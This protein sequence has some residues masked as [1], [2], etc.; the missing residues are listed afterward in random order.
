[1]SIEE[2]FDSP[3]TDNL[4]WLDDPYNDDVVT[5]KPL[6][7][8]PSCGAESNTIEEHDRLFTSLRRG[9]KHTKN[10]INC[11]TRYKNKTPGVSRIERRAIE[12]CQN[13]WG[14]TFE[15]VTLIRQVCMYVGGYYWITPDP[16]T[17]KK[18]FHRTP[19]L[20]RDSRI[21]RSQ[22]KINQYLAL[23]DQHGLIY[24]RG[25]T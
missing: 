20:L 12:F 16:H 21:L 4:S 19:K 7:R 22:T 5:M 25:D 13:T 18:P 10:C 1:M 14:L 6:H 15:E 11:R 3:D 8:C 23:A 2:S 9:K 24:P 17:G